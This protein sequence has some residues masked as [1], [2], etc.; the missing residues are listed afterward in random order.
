MTNSHKLETS[1]WHEVANENNPFQADEVY[2]H[3]F[4]VYNDL[5][6]NASWTAYIYLLISGERATRAQ[7]SLLEKSSIVLANPGIRDLGVRAAM[8]AGVG[9]APSASTLIAA[10][11]AGSGQFSGGRELVLSMELWLKNI[12]LEEFDLS[13]PCDD[14]KSIWP[15]LEHTPGFELH[16]ER[17][18]KFVD[19]CL[20]QL[21]DVSEGKYLQWLKRSKL[22]LE[23]KINQPLSLIGVLAA[24]FCDLDLSPQQSE[25]LFLILRLPGAAAHAM[26]QQKL[27]WQK[28]PFFQDTVNLVT[29]TEKSNLPDIE[30]LVEGYINESK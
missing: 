10:L 23:R 26:E 13:I 18:A 9:K 20:E 7:L 4:D 25:Y 17:S 11:S 5:L 1:I 28:F 3:G 8:N 6:T 12:S 19:I 27:G 22:A 14:E 29:D 2:C 21:A 24:A 15:S 30:N 16:A